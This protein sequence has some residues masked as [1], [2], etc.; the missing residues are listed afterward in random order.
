MAEASPYVAVPVS[1]VAVIPI[2]KA[3]KLTAE[4]GARCA[5][6]ADCDCVVTA[7][8]YGCIDTMD[9]PVEA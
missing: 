2:G 8:V 9:A 4:F 7:V 5:C 6:V 1:A 3:L